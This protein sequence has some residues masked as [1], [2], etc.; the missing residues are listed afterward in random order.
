MNNIGEYLKKTKNKLFLE[1]GKREISAEVISEF[2]NEK[3][4]A[5]NIEIKSGVI[6]VKCNQMLRASLFM[7]KEKIIEEI[8]KKIPGFNIKDIR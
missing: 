4:P 6:Y 3:I 2:L 1:L 7:K 5:K 8:K